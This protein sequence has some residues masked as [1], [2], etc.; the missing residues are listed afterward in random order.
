MRLLFA[1]LVLAVVAGCGPTKEEKAEAERQAAEDQRKAEIA[2]L[3]KPVLGQLKDPS[4]AQFE[5]EFLTEAGALCGTV[6]S[7]ND[8]GAYVGARKFLIVPGEYAR[9]RELPMI[10][11]RDSLQATADLESLNAKLDEYNARKRRELGLPVEGPSSLEQ[12]FAKVF[13]KDWSTRCLEVK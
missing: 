8:Y 10:V 12:A 9:L 2:E 1:G 3:R 4:S 6:N 5:G 7:K 11:I 13:D